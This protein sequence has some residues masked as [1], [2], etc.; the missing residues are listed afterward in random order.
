ML[1]E[2][3]EFVVMLSDKTLVIDES[4]F[5]IVDSLFGSS[6]CFHCLD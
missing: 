2:F 5:Q 3:L 4:I 1:V 6:V